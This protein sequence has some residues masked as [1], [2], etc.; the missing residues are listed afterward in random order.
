[1]PVRGRP[2][3]MLLRK[4]HIQLL[5]AIA[6]GAVLGYLFPRAGPY[7]KPLADI[8]IRLVRMVLA[9]IVFTTIVVGIARM[10]DIKSVG[11]V[12]VKALLYFEIVSSLA[13]LIGLLVVNLARPGA[14]MNIDPAK[15]DPNLV[16]NYATASHKLTFLDFILNIIP[17]SFGGAFVEGSLLPVIL[18]SI[19]FGI[20]LSHLGPR[21]RELVRLLEV[22][23]DAMF[24]IVRMIMY[25]AP[26]AA[27]GSIAFII[28]QFGPGKLL[29]YAKLVA[30]LYFSCVAF[31]FCVLGPVARAA[32]VS[33]PRFLRYIRGEILIVFGTCSTESV[34]PQLMKKLEALGCDESVVGLVLP[35]GYSFNADGTSIYLSLAA[36]F[37]AQAM[38]VPLTLGDQL[39]VLSV[40]LLTS[41]GSAGVAGAGFVTLAATLGSM[42][43]I[44][45]VGIVLLLGVESLLNQARAVTN[46]IGNGVATIAV[47]RWEGRLDTAQLRAI[48]GE[49]RQISPQKVPTSV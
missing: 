22:F 29:P 32:G 45:V 23:R 49:S 5:I 6:V 24:G 36:I 3:L 4:L 47:A 33:L 31:I 9:P 39:L 19:L 18:L 7:L 35:A 28:G 43:K 40:L 42:D 12:G 34:L 38:N 25:L 21:S 16:A 30:C 17:T 14:G 13:L 48:L 2:H 41:K 44:P 20:A 27:M 46:I 8:F 1:M 26:L 11:R 37:I 15:L 10:S